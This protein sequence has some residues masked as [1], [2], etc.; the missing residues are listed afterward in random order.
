VYGGEP[1]ELAGTLAALHARLAH[2]RKTNIGFPGA[3]DFDFTELAPFL[4]TLLNNV[5]D[6]FV[7]GVGGAHTK[8]LEVA[9]LDWLADLFRAPADDRWGYVT[10][11]GSEANL[12]ALTLARET[13]PAGRVY[14][15]AAVHESIVKAVDILRMPRLVVRAAPNGELD[16]EDLRFVLSQYRHEPAIV[17]ANIGT[18][19]TEAIDDVPRIKQTLRSLAMGA[20][21][22]HSDAALSGVPLA[23]DEGPPPGFDLAVGGADTICVSGHKFIGS[24]FPYGV[25]LTRRSLVG[26]TARPGSYTASPDTTIAG[27]RSGHAPLFLWYRLTQLGWAD[28]LRARAK[29]SRELAEYAELRL[30]AIGWDAWR[31]H[32]RAF[33]VVLRTPPREVTRDRG[34]ALACQDEW[35]H[36]ICMPGVTREQIDAFVGDLEAS[37]QDFRP[38]SAQARTPPAGLGMNPRAPA[39]APDL[40]ALLAHQP[41]TAWQRLRQAD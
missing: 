4:A 21:F 38:A 32:P 5:G 6:P 30:R 22:V 11:G 17:V 12:Y 33:T 2:H 23:L 41:D 37:L 3:V 20:H 29:R 1:D 28:G 39:H 13:Y 26:R 14:F 15:S 8:D 18:T 19:M 35:S 36:L 24:P 9:V 31:S 27:S 16:Y 34:W 7:P 25:V 40:L 10:S